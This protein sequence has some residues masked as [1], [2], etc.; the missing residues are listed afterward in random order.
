MLVGLSRLT[1]CFF[2]P[3][4]FSVPPFIPCARSFDC[5]RSHGLVSIGVAVGIKSEVWPSARVQFLRYLYS[6]FYFF[7]PEPFSVRPFIPCARSFDS[8]RSHGL[9]L[10][11]VAVGIKTE[12]WLSARVQ[13]LRSPCLEMTGGSLFSRAKKAI[14]RGGSS[15]GGLSRRE[16]S[17]ETGT[18][19]TPVH[20]DSQEE[21]ECSMTQQ[22]PRQSFCSEAPAPE[23]GV[24]LIDEQGNPIR[25]TYLGVVARDPVLAPIAFPDWRNKGMEPFKKKMLAEVESKFEF[26]GH[27]R[28]W[29]LQSLGV[30]WRNYKTTLKAEHWDSRPIEEIMENILDGVY[31]MQWC[32]L[33]TQWSKPEDQT[34][35]CNLLAEEGL[36]PEDGNIEANERVFT[37]V[38]GPEHLVR[39]R[40][41]GFGVTPTRYFPQSKSEE[42]GGSGSNFRQ[43]ASLRE[44]FRS[45]R[46]NQ[47]RE[48]G[49][50][51][52]EMRQFMQQFQ[53][54]QSSH[55]GSEMGDN[56]NSSDA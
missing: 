3:E 26:P 28:H 11:G 31:Q 39:V 50:F 4:P 33:V 13:F 24:W 55:G 53:M 41:Q 22:T 19:S 34:Q 46:D 16:S 54:N 23:E 40:T 20:L 7:D 37:I 49:S 32:Q 10:I 5:S 30:K 27:I 17:R 44:E 12:V 38:M 8:S 1:F 47:M 6:A 42:G 45:F 14:C 56:D 18:P 51:R 52:D 36:T 35:A 25:R 29:I 9:V 48:F 43:M 21:I 2:D 15:R